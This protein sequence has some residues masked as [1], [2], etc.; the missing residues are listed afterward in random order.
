ML[1]LD[2]NEIRVA[3]FIVVPLALLLLIVA[4][5]LGYSI[6]GSTIDVYLKVDSISSIKKGTNVKIKGHTIGRV[7]EIQPVYK[8]A[9]HF[10]ATMRIDNT[11][12]L[13]ENCAAVIQNQNII[14]DPVIELRNPERPADLLAGGSVIEGIEHVNLE[15]ILQD[16]HNLLAN[17]N[18]AIGVFKE[19][20]LQ[21][22]GNIRSMMQNLA[23]SVANLNSILANLQRDFVAILSSFRET[24]KTFTEIS[25]ELKKRPMGFIIRGKKDEPGEKKPDEQK[26]EA[27][28]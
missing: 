11:V 9:L 26:P 7:V 15:V 24:A 6:E 4:V 16:V 17:T 22:K 3:A 2:S 8:P 27:K 19:I 12:G 1:K 28:K 5:K 14:G 10:L 23:N 25:A 21:S 20:Q 18:A 13:F